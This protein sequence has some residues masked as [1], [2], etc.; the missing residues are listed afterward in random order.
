M[1]PYPLKHKQ[2]GIMLLGMVTIL[3]FIVA[4]LSLNHL[5]KSNLK[6]LK[7]RKTQQ[8]LAEAKQALLSYSSETVTLAAR[9]SIENR[10]IK[11]NKNGT[12]SKSDLPYCNC[13]TNCPRPGD[14][15]CPDLNND[16]EA[17]LSCN[18]ET[19]QLGRFPWKTLG[20]ND[21]RDGSGESLWYAVSTNYKNSPRTGTL[22]S[23]TLGTITLKN[24]GGHLIH[25]A[26][27]ATGL[28]ALLIAPNDPLLRADK[29]QQN[30]LS[31]NHN[32]PQ[33]YLDNAFGEDNANFTENDLNGFISG[34]IKQNET[35][36]VNDVILPIT[37]EQMN[38]AIEPRVLA[39]VIQAVLYQYCPN[40]IDVHNRSCTNIPSDAYFPAPAS[41]A[42]T[43]CLPTTDITSNC[44]ADESLTLGR[45]PA[46]EVD[47]T[48]TPS[49]YNPIWEATNVNSILQGS[50]QHNWFQQNGWRELIFYARATAAS[51]LTLKHALTPEAAPEN[52]GKLVILISS[53]AMIASQSRGDLT[54]QS[55][56]SNYLEDENLSLPVN[57]FSRLTKN[58]SKNDKVMSI[59]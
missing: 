50:S 8:V 33:H 26:T 46:S 43:S 28:V 54:S 18:N 57:T 52:G 4:G 31:N 1:S 12:I 16:G 2:Q 20:L 11:Y 14:L 5:N 36:V 25:D 15:P 44:R 34:V 6:S 32:N 23:Q 42:D 47:E 3:A 19:R 9:D 55:T 45:I 39:E 41:I 38:A 49:T 35:V 40:A 13:G 29:L 24:T 51:A 56:L 53:G 59:P 17:E 27:N 10:C 21:L 7:D 48:I 37:R 58:N 30:R 22:N